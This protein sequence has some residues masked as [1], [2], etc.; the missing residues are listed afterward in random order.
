MERT[1][2]ELTKERWFELNF[3]KHFWGLRSYDGVINVLMTPYKHLFL[4][5]Y[6]SGF[7]KL[8]STSQ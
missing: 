6:V 4:S 8:V 2:I 3:L 7:Y 1:S 5:G